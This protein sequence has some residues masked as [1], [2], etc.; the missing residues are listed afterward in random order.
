MPKKF[1]VFVSWSGVPAQKCALLLREKLPHFNHLIEPFVSSK[2][3]AKGDRGY[4]AIAAQL[5]DSQFGIV[6]VTPENRTEPWIHFEAG[7]LSREVGKPKLAPLLLL[8]TTV[9]D[10]V[11]T[12]LTQFQAT[13]AETEEDVLSL[14][15]SINKLCDPPADERRLED[16]FAKYWPEL[17]DGL[18]EITRKA[19]EQQPATPPPRPS[20]EEV[21]NQMLSLLLNQVDRIT[22]LQRTVD[23]LRA[24]Q[25]RQHAKVLF[26]GL[27]AAAEQPGAAPEP[28]SGS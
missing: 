28:G 12:P 11:G 10:L 20:A 15:K 8:G 14:I 6:C 4:D 27:F 23:G 3:I 1:K 7:A 24:E 9:A 26:D 2:D 18:D 13:S 17:R 5:R 21:Q 16:L 22:A 25:S 19:K